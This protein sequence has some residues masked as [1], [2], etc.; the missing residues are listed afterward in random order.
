MN[1][2][3]RQ[4]A[5]L[6]A[7]WTVCELLLPDGKHQHM[8]RMTAGLLVMTALLTTVS[9]WLG[10]VPKTI[11]VMTVAVQNASEEA[12]RR[13]ALKASANQIENWC[14]R[15][16]ER[17]GYQASVTVYLTMD[18]ALDHMQLIVRP[19]EQALITAER[20]DDML[21]EQLGVQPEQIRI[22]VEET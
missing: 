10:N 4:I 15:L 5:V 19:S 21:A 11:P 22:S 3:I 9:G 18:G 7:L 16:A 6:S 20:L 2:L 17:A 1:A 14:R 12:Y 8:V 13:T